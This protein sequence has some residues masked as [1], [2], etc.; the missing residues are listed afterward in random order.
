MKASLSDLLTCPR[1]GP[2]W[3]LVLMPTRSMGRWVDEGV[4]GCPNCRERYPITGGVA[5]LEVPGEAPKDTGVRE[6]R[7]TAGDDAAVRLGGLLGLGEGGGTVILAGP[8]AAHA[9]ALAALL[10][11]IDVLTVVGARPGAPPSLDC[12][13]G[14][15]AAAGEGAAGDTPAGEAAI[16]REPRSW[17]ALRVSSALPVRS[18]GVRAVALTGWAADWLEE[19]ARLVS[20]GGRLLVEPAPADAGERVDAAGLRTLAR[21]GETVVAGR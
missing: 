15:E 16:E 17:S 13:A 1:C 20:P 11:D 6:S 4:L 18:R 12:A 21:E 14:G 10:P 3:G 2:E 9:G 19:G 7:P 8:A 5:E